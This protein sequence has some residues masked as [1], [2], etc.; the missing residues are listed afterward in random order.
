MNTI[1]RR[2]FLKLA[3]GIGLGIAIAPL[4]LDAASPRNL[5]R[6]WQQANQTPLLFDV[7]E[8]GTLSVADYPEPKTRREVFGISSNWNASLT[9]PFFSDQFNLG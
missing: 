8:Y 4:Q 3:S 5:D 6:L 1:S 7:T 9:C 2:K